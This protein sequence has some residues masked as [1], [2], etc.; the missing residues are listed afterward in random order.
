MACRVGAVLLAS[1]QIFNPRW[2][3]QTTT[4]R[5]TNASVLLEVVLALALF[6]FAASVITGGLNASVQEAERLRLNVHATNLA[7]SILSELQMGIKPVDAAGPEPFEVPFQMWTWQVQISPVEDGLENGL[8]LRNVEVVVRH[9][10]RPIVR[11]LAQ[12]LLAS[13]ANAAASSLTNGSPASMG[14]RP[15]SNLT[16]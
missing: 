6:V 11:R 10:T 7:I 4:A 15:S 3:R 9:Q 1:T 12:F 2:P 16:F 5:S 14:D 13:P 8:P